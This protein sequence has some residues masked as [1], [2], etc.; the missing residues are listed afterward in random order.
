MAEDYYSIKVPI[1]YHPELVDTDTE[2]LNCYDP[3][4]MPIVTYDCD[5][6][7]DER[8]RGNP[9]KIY[10]TRRYGSRFTWQEFRFSWEGV[11]VLQPVIPLADFTADSCR[12]QK[13]MAHF[14]E[15]PPKCSLSTTIAY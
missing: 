2:W 10:L 9:E 4:R 14:W 8:L 11:I 3:P 5:F 15:E 12:E 1:W 7:F 13:R 6:Y